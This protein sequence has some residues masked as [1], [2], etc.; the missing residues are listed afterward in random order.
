MRKSS[1][2]KVEKLR[3]QELETAGHIPIHRQE[4]END[5]CIC[6]A[7]QFSFSVLY[8]LGPPAQEMVPPIVHAF[9]HFIKCNQAKSSIDKRRGHIPRPF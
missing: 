3:Q 4:A 8:S 7:A 9:S 6:D 5:E 1:G 2:L